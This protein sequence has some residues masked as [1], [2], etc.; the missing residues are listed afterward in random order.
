M[1]FTKYINHSNL[2][3]LLAEAK[4]SKSFADSAWGKVSYDEVCEHFYA[5]FEKEREVEFAVSSSISNKVKTQTVKDYLISTKETKR[6]G[7]FDNFA[8]EYIIEK[9]DDLSEIQLN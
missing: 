4:L 6:K 7:Q 1:S 2:S 3:V 8:I 5:I 9:I